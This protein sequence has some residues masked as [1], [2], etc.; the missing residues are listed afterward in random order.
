[1]P[2]TL[3]PGRLRLSTSP[4]RTGSAPMVNT[5]G[6]LAPLASFAARAEATSPVAAMAT[7]PL[8]INSPANDGNAE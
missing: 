3:P 5:T 1:M 7:T 8:A 2:V 6:T 4:N